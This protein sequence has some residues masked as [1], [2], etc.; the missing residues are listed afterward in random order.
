[1]VITWQSTLKTYSKSALIIEE[2]KSTSIFKSKGEKNKGESNVFIFSETSKSA[3]MCRVKNRN[4]N[5]KP[6]SVS[7]VQFPVSATTCEEA[8]PSAYLPCSPAIPFGLPFELRVPLG[9]FK[10]P[11]LNT[12][13]FIWKLNSSSSLT[14]QIYRQSVIIIHSNSLAWNIHDIF[15]CWEESKHDQMLPVTRFPSLSAILMLF[16]FSRHH[17]DV[18]SCHFVFGLVQLFSMDILSINLNLPNLYCIPFSA[19]IITHKLQ[20]NF[21]ILSRNIQQLALPSAN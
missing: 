12:H 21:Y 20:F 9:Y 3:L 7:V 16:H 18:G 1:M 11:N 13:K 19:G 6:L 5:G 8:A 17:C 14:F 4:P 2:E 10:F 15:G